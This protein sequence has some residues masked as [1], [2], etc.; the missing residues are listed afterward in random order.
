MTLQPDASPHWGTSQLWTWQGLAC[1]WQ[2]LGERT[3]PALLLL[4]GFGASSGHWRR[5][6]APLA[7]GASMG[8]I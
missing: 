3:R 7:A 2:V 8:W 4:H 1:H 5:N 6:A